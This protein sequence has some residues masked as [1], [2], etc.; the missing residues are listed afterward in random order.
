MQ[1]SED[2]K[3]LLK[4]NKLNCKQEEVSKRR[5]PRGLKPRASGL[6][7]GGLE[8]SALFFCKCQNVHIYSHNEK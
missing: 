8:N 2:R 6:M 3:K 7:P 4:Q 5:Q 1:L